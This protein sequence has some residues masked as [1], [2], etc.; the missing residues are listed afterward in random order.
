MVGSASRTRGRDGIAPKRP[1]TL[2]EIQ[3]VRS[4]LAARQS[5]ERD[6]IR[7]SELPKRTY[8]VARKRLLGA[9]VV[10][11][12]W[13]PDPRTLGFGMVTFDLESGSPISVPACVRERA[14][15]P[16]S[17][18]VWGFR[19]LFLTVSFWP[20]ASD[21]RTSAEHAPH[22]NSRSEVHIRAPLDGDSVAVF[23]DFEAAWSAVSGIAG[24]LTY[25]KGIPTSGKLISEDGSVPTS[26]RERLWLARVLER[27]ES[28]DVGDRGGVHLGSA[29][30]DLTLR[31][32]I[33]RKLLSRR[34]FID[35]SRPI[36]TP[37]WELRQ[38]VF[39]QGRRR[40]GGSLH[41]LRRTLLEQHRSAPFLFVSDDLQVLMGFLSPA[42]ASLVRDPS[43][44]LASTLSSYLDAL[45]VFRCDVDSAKTAVNHDYR[46]LLR[47][48]I[49]GKVGAT[50]RAS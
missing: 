24:S 1:L 22:A 15:W 6:R 49:F 28:L 2:A 14:G 47:A 36:A 40:S 3:V 39:V 7:E 19:E 43:V 27:S 5:S 20:T 34:G 25:P 37:G 45:R 17:T 8:E 16:T 10:V 48:S 46:K 30:R 12:R 35:P 23:F 26:P 4:I 11:D 42:P 29:L 31:R 41:A 18:L 44:S 9:G 32:V 33:N 13:V 50:V 38:I 21:D